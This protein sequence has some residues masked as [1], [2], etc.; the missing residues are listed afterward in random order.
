MGPHR[1]LPARLDEVPSSKKQVD[2]W[3]AQAKAERGAG[4][5]YLT[6]LLVAVAVMI[7]LAAV[8]VQLSV[9]RPVDDPLGRL[10]GPR[11]RS[12]SLQTLGMFGKLVRRHHGYKA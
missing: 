8:W 1:P 2:N 9:L 5:A 6:P 4:N 12:P 7:A 11:R 10:A 3:A